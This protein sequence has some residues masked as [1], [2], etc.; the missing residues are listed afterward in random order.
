M[1][2]LSLQYPVWF[3]DIWGVL[4]NGVE[5]NSATVDTLQRHRAL[6][7]TVILVSNSPRSTK[8]LTRQLDDIGVPGNCYDAAVT[9]GDVTRDLMQQQHEGKFFHLGPE[10]DA[11]IFDGLAISRV[12]LADATAVICTGL[13]HD[14]RETPADYTSL[15]A[16]IRARNLTFICANPDKVVRKG[17]QLLYCAGALAEAYEKLGGTVQMAGKPFKPIYDLAR[18]RAATIR[19]HDVPIEAILAIGDGPE[20]DIKG[21]A[22]QDMACVFVTGLDDHADKDP[23]AAIRKAIPR[24]RILRTVADLTWA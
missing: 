11:S 23:D 24:A 13:Y 17:A 4:H 14:T 7:G 2:D 21:A 6:G 8:G 1:H 5:P 12:P 9:S 15:L 16:D 22:N 3:C 19:D 20:T 10:R 18:R